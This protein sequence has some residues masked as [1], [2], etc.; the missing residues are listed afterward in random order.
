[1]R[2]RDSLQRDMYRTTL[3]Y[4]DE[5]HPSLC[6]IILCNRKIIINQLI[7]HTISFFLMA[8]IYMKGVNKWQ[9]IKDDSE[10]NH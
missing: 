9:I 5:Y 10:G 2:S 6:S 3:S 1:M 4:N 7:I 8:G